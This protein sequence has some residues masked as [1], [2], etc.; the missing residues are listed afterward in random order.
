MSNTPGVIIVSCSNT[1]PKSLIKLITKSSEI[2]EDNET[3]G[4]IEHLWSIDTKYYTAN[5]KL[6]GLE[7]DFPR[8]ERF[9]NNIEAIIILMDSN[10]SRGLEDLSKWD[11]F[12]HDCN[13]EVKLLVSN[14]CNNDT[15]VTKS[16]ALEWCLKR[17]FEFIELFPTNNQNDESEEDLIK[18]KF[19]VD[20]VVE[21]L[22]SHTWSNL[23]MK[24]RDKSN[25]NIGSNKESRT[26][27]DVLNKENFLPD[28]DVD[29]FTE[30]FSQ[31]HMMKD[32]LQSM[33]MSQRKQCAEHM[34]TAFWKAMGGE[35]EELFDL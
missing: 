17:G 8:S 23:V 1:K 19:G 21:A 13:L 29:D 2:T 12:E 11:V 7:N 6:I 25:E 10:K 9:N 5:I 20:R 24:V 3:P 18:E 27:N 16:D 4:L 22:H 34:V 35:E 26:S 30:L 28:D 33:P 14:Y 15:K 32:S 31:L